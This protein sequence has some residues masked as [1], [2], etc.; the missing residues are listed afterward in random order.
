MGFVAVMALIFTVPFI[1]LAWSAI[2]V[3][4][5]KREKID[6][7]KPS[8]LLFI[9]LA[10]VGAMNYYFYHTYQLPFWPNIFEGIVGLT[11]TGAILFIIAIVNIIVS[12]I[13][14]GAPKSF[15]DPKA[16]WAFTGILGVAFL[17]L[18]SLVYPTAQ[19]AAYVHKI[20]TAMHAL[21]ES[22]PDKEVTVL[23]MNSEKNCVRRRTES[24]SDE[25]YQNYFFV[26]NN[27]AEEKDVQVR[28]R[29]LNADKEELK[30]V[31]SNIMTL[32]AG[33]LRLVETEET[34]DKTSI[35]SKS[36]F[37]TEYQTYFYEYMYR[38]R[39][40]SKN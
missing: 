11:V 7:K 21:A 19:K 8:I 29:A 14:K 32:S 33:E 3:G 18:F 10:L 6:W 4:N 13:H 22:E 40:P 37:E 2:D 25:G 17:L 34:N 1:W 9:I 23:F 15:H 16:V 27:L 36:T 35:W 39:D 20:E 38:F 28:I 31:D 30:V 24:C 5:G 12:I 26:K